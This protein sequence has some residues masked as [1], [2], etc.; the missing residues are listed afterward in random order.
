MQANPV[1]A[2]VEASSDASMLVV[3][4]RGRGGFASLLLGSVSTGCVHHA[5]VPVVVIDDIGGLPGCGDVV[6]GVDDSKGAA[7]A[8]WWA[9]SEAGRLGVRL[10]VVHGRENQDAMPPG[11][12]AF[13]ELH[14]TEF[15]ASAQR[16]M[17]DMV[18]QAK[19]G[20]EH[21]P[22]EVELRPVELTAPEALLHEAKGAGLLVVGSRGRGGFAGLILGSVSQQCVHHAPCPVA[23]IP[24][25]TS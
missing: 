2:L 19:A 3:G 23:V 18:D 12:L 8:L 14:R 6:V 25:P 16:L 22:A 20:L 17:V 11:G 4:T 13:S 15:L 5:K 9:A 10:T 21:P 7:A 1:Q 24:Q